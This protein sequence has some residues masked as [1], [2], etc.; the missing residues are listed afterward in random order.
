M[1]ARAAISTVAALSSRLARRQH[2][3]RARSETFATAG[4]YASRVS[5][6]VAP[7]TAWR[8]RSRRRRRGAE[9]RN[10]PHG[11]AARDL[12]S[13]RPCRDGD[14]ARRRSAAASAAE[15]PGTASL[16]TSG[17]ARDPTLRSRRRKL[18]RWGRIGSAHSRVRGLRGEPGRFTTSSCRRRPRRERKHP[19][20]VFSSDRARSASAIPSTH[21]RPSRS[22]AASRRSVRDR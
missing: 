4:S 5:S 6:D 3:E 17:R 18:D 22:P 21:G 11:T 13:R 20:A 16:T 9:A 10:S 2:R 19:G 8:P 15:H 14:S 12:R 1:P 7:T